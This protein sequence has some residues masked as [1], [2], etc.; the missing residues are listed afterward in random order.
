MIW[1]R[2]LL[3]AAV[4]YA[5]STIAAIA[6]APLLLGPRRWIIVTI[7]VWARVV[8]VFLRLICG[9]KVEVRGR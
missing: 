8:M 4:F 9:V 3:F 5:V 1:V 2:S 6:M 7:G